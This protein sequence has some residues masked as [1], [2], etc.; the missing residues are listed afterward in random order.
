MTQNLHF[1]ILKSFNRIEHMLIKEEVID[2]HI[3]KVISDFYTSM[4]ITQY[5]FHSPLGF[6]INSNNTSFSSSRKENQY[7]SS[8]KS[9]YDVESYIKIG[10]REFQQLFLQNTI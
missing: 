2:A 3:F 7:I 6:V 10:V 9:L 4:R 5:V 1:H 8:F